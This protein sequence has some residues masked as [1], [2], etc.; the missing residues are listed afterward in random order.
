MWE[1]KFSAVSR[2]TQY[3]VQGAQQRR[4]VARD[5]DLGS[6]KLYYSIVPLRSLSCDGDLDAFH[7]QVLPV[8]GDPQYLAAWAV[9]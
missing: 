5:H 6:L 3:V 9:Q 1:S 7:M 4:R 8:G 2:M